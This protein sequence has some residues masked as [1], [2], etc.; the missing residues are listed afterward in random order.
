VPF[1]LLGFQILLPSPLQRWLS[2]SCRKPIS[3]TRAINFKGPFATMPILDFVYV[4]HLLSS[5]EEQFAKRPQ[6]LL[7]DFCAILNFVIFVVEDSSTFYRNDFVVVCCLLS[8]V[9]VVFAS[10]PDSSELTDMHPVVVAFF[11]LLLA[12]GG[13]FVF[14]AVDG[15][16]S[17]EWKE[18]S[19]QI[20]SSVQFLSATVWIVG[21]FVVL[22]LGSLVQKPAIL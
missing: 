20:A 18:R 17:T 19:Q 5:S 14:L 15:T 3:L 13:F 4:S 8:F 6:K 12:I 1:Q 16:S 7:P 11:F 21:A 10:K 9:C 2:R 22:A